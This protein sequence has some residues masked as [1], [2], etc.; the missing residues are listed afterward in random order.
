MQVVILGQIR[1]PG[2]VMHSGYTVFIASTYEKSC[3]ESPE[4]SPHCCTLQQTLHYC[5]SSKVVAFSLILPLWLKRVAFKSTVLKSQSESEESLVLEDLYSRFFFLFFLLFFFFFSFFLFFFL[6]RQWSEEEE[7]D[8][9][10]S[11][12]E[13]VVS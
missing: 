10:L 13:E 8:E 4:W 2:E 9:E 7:E 11:E 1:Q 5:L 3:R 6:L 12:S